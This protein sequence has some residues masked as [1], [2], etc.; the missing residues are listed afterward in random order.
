MKIKESLSRKIFVVLNY[1]FLTLLAILCI[2][3][4]WNVLCISFSENR[5][6]VAGQVGLLPKGFTLDAY[7]YLAQKSGFLKSFGVS[8]VRVILGSVVNMVMCII[9]AYPLSRSNEQLH[10]RTVYTWFFAITMFFGGG[11]IPTYFVI[12]KTG[13]MDTIWALIIPG[14]LSFWN[15][16][17]MINFFRG[18][19]RELDEAAMVDGAGHIKILLQIYLPLSKASLATILL[20]TVVGHWN[21]WFDGYLYLNSPS[22]YPLQ[23][24]LMSVINSV[25]TISKE[26]L[27]PEEIEALANVDEKTIRM[28]QIFLS[29]LPVM[30]VYPFLQRY[31]VKGLVV[32]SVKG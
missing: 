15:C 31:F 13:I 3:P 23:T 32:G 17:M 16:T 12:S 7:K 9:T 22:K 18:I 28:A 5:Y 10:F 4:I 30:C 29:A 14:A 24:Y 19:P 20:F 8:V 11:M 1:T 21:S 25:A 6:A 27:T 2:L 26:F